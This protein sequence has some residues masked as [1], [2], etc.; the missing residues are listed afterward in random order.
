MAPSPQEADPCHDGRG[1][2]RRIDRNQIVLRIVLKVHE[3]CGHEHEGRGGEAY[4][5]VSAQASWTT[6]Y[7]AL[8]ADDRRQQRADQETSQKLQ[9]R[10]HQDAYRVAG[11][12]PRT[13]AVRGGRKVSARLTASAPITNEPL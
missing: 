13:A 5:K 1:N 4:Q 2:T 11:T 8:V 10:D 3:L 12:A 9:L 6:V 7:M